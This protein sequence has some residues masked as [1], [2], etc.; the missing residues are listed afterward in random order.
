MPQRRSVQPRVIP[1][2][3]TPDSAA[4]AA[5]ADDSFHSASRHVT[6]AESSQFHSVAKRKII[7]TNADKQ[8]IDNSAVT[9]KDDK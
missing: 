8:I 9:S 6:L 3:E 4:E 7:L 5:A 1:S 2:H